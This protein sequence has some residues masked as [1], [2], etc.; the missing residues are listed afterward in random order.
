MPER[1]S[2][3]VGWRQLADSLGRGLLSGSDAPGMRADCMCK[4]CGRRTRIILVFSASLVWA[5]GVRWNGTSF[6]CSLSS[7]AITLASPAGH[8]PWH[9]FPSRNVLP[10]QG[11]VTVFL[12]KNCS[13]I[14]VF[15]P[16]FSGERGVSLYHNIWSMGTF[17]NHPTSDKYSA[18]ENYFIPKYFSS[19]IVPHS[20]LR[21]VLSAFVTP[22]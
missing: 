11:W 15:F 5:L 2:F 4:Q 22:N 9:C 18:H 10:P 8:R 13:F 16:L 12:G 20:L 14:C 3:G 19:R 6:N 21:A 17:W 1:V 7:Y